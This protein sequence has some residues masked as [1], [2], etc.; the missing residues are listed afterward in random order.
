[1]WYQS[2]YES[3]QSCALL[4]TA[5]ETTSV[6]LPVRTRYAYLCMCT[7]RERERKRARGR[8]RE[9]ERERYIHIYILRKTKG[10]KRVYNHTTSKLGRPR[11][12]GPGHH[13]AALGQR[14]REEAAVSR[15]RVSGGTSTSSGVQSRHHLFLEVHPINFHPL[16]Q[17]CCLRRVAAI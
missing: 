8:E 16:R 9:G 7:Y 17:A 2:E 14:P 4:S 3:T 12:N 11:R 13:L 10:P 5:S 6:G 1:M 15:R